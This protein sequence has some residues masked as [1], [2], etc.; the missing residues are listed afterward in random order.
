MMGKRFDD[1]TIPAG[2]ACR[3]AICRLW[4]P[5]IVDPDNDGFPDLVWV[6]GN[7]YPKW[8][9][10]SSIPVQTPRVI[11][12]NK[13]RTD[14]QAGPAIEAAHPSRGCAGDFDNDGDGYL[15]SI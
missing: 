2:L 8:K 14:R 11:N 13:L 3:N 12:L 5:S 9:L 1:V 10:N 15:A 6:M 4:A 7:V